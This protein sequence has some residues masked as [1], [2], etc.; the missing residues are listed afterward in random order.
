MGIL[1]ELS[2]LILLIKIKKERYISPF[3]FL[4]FKNV[5]FFK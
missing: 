1:K 2:K 5:S 4:F 3:L